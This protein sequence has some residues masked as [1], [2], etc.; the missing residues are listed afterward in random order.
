MRTFGNLKVHSIFHIRKYFK[1]RQNSKYLQLKKQPA[2]CL[3]DNNL[4][5]ALEFCLKC[6]ALNVKPIIGCSYY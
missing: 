4:H 3:T 2:V 6:K 1:Y 5:G